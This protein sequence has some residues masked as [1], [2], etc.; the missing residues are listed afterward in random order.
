MSTGLFGSILTTFS[1]LISIG[2][3]MST[4]AV[5]AQSASLSGPVP[6]AITLAPGVFDKPPPGYVVEERFIS[7]TATSYALA[8]GAPVASTGTPLATAEFRSRI[9]VARPQ[10][11][12]MFNGTVIVEW[13]NVTGGTDGA[14]DW[15]Y[16]HREIIRRGYAYVG[17]SAQNV[18]LNGGTFAMPGILPIRKANP[19]RYGALLHPGDAFAFD[20]YTQAGKLVADA[21]SNGVLG[22]LQPKRVISIGES[23]SAAFL[24]TYV[25][26]VDP[27][28]KTFDGFLIHSRFRGA[29]PLD[30]N[31]LAS[32]QTKPGQGIAPVPFRTDLRVPVLNLITETDLL[33][34]DVGYFPARQPDTARLRTWEIA[35]AAHGDTYLME[36]GM[37]DTGHATVEDLARAFTPVA[38]LFGQPTVK[39]ISAAPQHHYVLEAGLRTLASWVET[40]NAPPQAAR[41]EVNGDTPPAMATDEIGN[42][43]G[44][45]RSP[46]VD[47]PTAIMSGLGQTPGGLAGLF[48]STVPLD[49]ST[50]ARLYPKGRAEYL[51]KFAAA[52]ETAIDGGY[53]LSDDKAEILDLARFLYPGH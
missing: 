51:A 9:V 20:I 52:L 13:L 14:P 18:G 7:G 44:G 29:A 26:S 39:P 12:A 35:G 37:L 10:D 19:E 27:L 28:A 43:R 47:A 8:S 24:V 6:G 3:S 31:F 50:L 38:S 1:A 48:G 21:A 22:G 33:S 15:T 49:Q 4:T 34:P 53:I 5:H 23:Q 32:F 11:P 30:G 16:V 2:L 40:G 41:I 42:T 45:V 17:V 46:W 36:G 25:N